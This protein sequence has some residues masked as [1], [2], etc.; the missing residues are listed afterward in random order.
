MAQGQSKQ[1]N[2]DAQAL[3]REGG[4]QTTTYQKE[5]IA[6]LDG[7]FRTDKAS[8][9]LANN[10][11]VSIVNLILLSNQLKVDTGYIPFGSIIGGAFLG[12]PQLYYQVFNPNGTSLDILVTTKTVYTRST[13]WNQWQ[14]LPW[15]SFYTNTGQVQAG[16]MSVLL[17]SVAGLSVGSVLGLPLDDAEQIVVTVTGIAGDVVSFTPAIPVGRFVPNASEVCLAAALNGTIDN[18]VVATS[19][20]PKGWIIFTNA[21]DPI[22]YF[23]GSKL[24]SLVAASDLPSGTTCVYMLMF[25]ESLFL[26][27]TLESGT[28][29]PQRIRMSDLGDPTAWTPGGK[30]GASIAAIY[31]QLDTEDFI[32]AASIVGPYLI[33]FRET[34]FMRGTYYGLLDET[35]FWEYTIYSEGV[36]SPGAIADIGSLQE[37]VGNGGIYQYAG[38][39]N[40][41]SEGDAVYQQFFSAVGSIFA[42]AKNTVFAQYCQDYDEVWVFFP[43]GSSLVPNTMLRHSL[44]KGG[45]Y[46][47]NF[48]NTF[49]SCN[50]YLPVDTVTWESAVG[51]WAEQVSQWDSKALL[52]L[53]A[54]LVLCSADTN[55]VYI[56]DY[57]NQS[58]NGTAIN[59]SFVTKD[60][61]PGDA[62]YRFDT[63]RFYGQ[64]NGVTVQFSTDGGKTWST[65]ASELNFGSGPSLQILTFETVG[66]YIRFMVSGSDPAFLFNWMEV[67]Y[68]WESDW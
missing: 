33:V 31:D 19:F 24:A 41:A 18:Q 23:D 29:L 12:T 30:S 48:A 46:Q 25:H 3:I 65:M 58:D 61:G 45:W 34:T 49:I 15:G 8:M 64:G 51:T 21:I 28:N 4:P 11:A 55:Q 50:P 1:V 5:R 60:I 27:A 35:M 44:E 67:W 7:G 20:P 40:L 6:I 47:R 9:D 54:N 53:V 22:F 57:K 66:P 39:Y 14:I 62:M 37:V 68:M 56:Y 43:T 36:I 16:N 13:L 17:T 59:W 2:Q 63:L 42:P 52:S 32:L 26:F 38:D 10:E